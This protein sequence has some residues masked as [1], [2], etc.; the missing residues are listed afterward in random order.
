MSLI[1]IL[2]TDSIKNSRAVI[3]DNF[4]YL[5]SDKA[6]DS[7]VV[8]LTTD[9]TIAGVKT[10]SSSPV[11]PTPTTDMQA[12][13]KKYAD[14]LAIAGSP[15]ASTTMKGIVEEATQ[16]EVDAGTA[17]GGSG[18][19]LFVNP[20]TRQTRYVSTQVYNSTPPTS[21]TDLDLS[22]VIGVQERIV[23]LSIRNTVTGQV[24]M[25]IIKSDSAGIVEWVVSDTGVVV[26]RTNGSSDPNAVN[27][28][29][30][31]CILM[32]G[33]GAQSYGHTVN[34]LAYW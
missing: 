27:A 29:V 12:A 2:G 11:V 8:K 4:I 25:I 33:I 26:F 32:S 23:M 19:R 28:G 30:R 16:A 7:V 13:T 34:V 22:G 5:E 1:E 6:E 20:S 24:G 15:N 9:Q 18:A 21:F 17:T 10:F 31:Q 14:D 3:N